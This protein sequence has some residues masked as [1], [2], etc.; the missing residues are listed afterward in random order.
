M[1][2]SERGEH[3]WLHT[4]RGLPYA[5]AVS[6]ERQTTRP[7][8]RPAPTRAIARQFEADLSAPVLAAGNRL[9][10]VRQISERVAMGRALWRELVIG[11]AGQLGDLRLGFTQ[12]A[13][14]YVLADSGTTTIADLADALNRSPSATSRLVDGLARR[15]Y[16]ERRP[17]TEDR[18]QRTLWL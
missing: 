11:F 1:F 7:S 15:G 17:E 4:Y 13:A 3:A 2:A 18:R 8:N 14:L 9:P 10:N 12:L 5:V 16:L 6:Q